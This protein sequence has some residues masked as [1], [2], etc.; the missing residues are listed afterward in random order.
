MPPITL[1][2]LPVL[3]SPEIQ[4]IATDVRAL[5][6]LDLQR[7]VQGERRF[8][9]HDITLEPTPAEPTPAEPTPAEPTPAEL[10]PRQLLTMPIG[11]S[12]EV[13]DTVLFE[14]AANPEKRY[15]L[16]RYELGELDRHELGELEPRVEVKYG[17]DPLGGWT[18]KLRLESRPAPELGDAARDAAPL[19]HTLAVLLRYRLTASDT[20]AEGQTEKVFQEVSFEK[21]GARVA[22]HVQTREERDELYRVLM[23]PNFAATL[24]V[25]RTMRVAFAQS[26]SGATMMHYNIS[27][28]LTGAAPWVIDARNEQDGGAIVFDPVNQILIPQGGARLASVPESSR[29]ATFEQLQSLDYSAEPFQMEFIS[30]ISFPV[31]HFEWHPPDFAVVTRSGLYAQVSVRGDCIL[32]PE[33]NIVR[34]IDGAWLDVVAMKE[35]PPPPPLF[36]EMTITLDH[37]LRKNPFV[38]PQELGYGYVFSD[39]PGTRG[40]E[41]PLTLRQLPWGKDARSYSYYQD[42]VEPHRFYYL[43]DSF[44]LVRQPDS[45]HVPALSVRYA[46]PDG[47]EAGVRATL[48]YAAC[49]YVDA[50]RL[51]AALREL[52]PFVKPPLPPGV[53]GPHLEPLLAEKT[54]LFMRLPRSDGSSVYQELPDAQ[55]DLR[56]GFFDSRTLTQEGF[57]TVFDA[58]FDPFAVLFQG[59]VE[60]VIPRRPAE[61]IPLVAR[62]DDMVGSVL[63]ADVVPSEG[64]TGLQVTLRNAI[65]SPVQL[66]ELSLSLQRG[67]VRTAGHLQAPF[68]ALPV[69]LKPEDALSFTVAPAEPLPGTG[70]WELAID[71]K[72]IKVLPERKELVKT[73]LRAD[74]LAEYKRT[75]DVWTTRDV[76]PSNSR[77]MS[78]EF[79]GGST[80]NF[81]REATGEQHANA[82]VS[83]PIKDLLIKQED[84]GTYEWRVM[85]ISWADAGKTTVHKTPEE[86][87]QWKKSTAKSLFVAT[88]DLPPP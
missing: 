58:L 54:R 41:S 62:L 23:N 65:E 39:L 1:S 67:S 10:K 21:G 68:P 61:R 53:T 70:R 77:F 60:V 33:D 45:P 57:R 37:T 50:A 28:H 8:R 52:A 40:S 76:F 27:V 9:I 44:K 24:V 49:P 25:R 4:M 11:L 36:R 69:T 46:S 29:K 32:S 80:I 73:V 30:R 71:P 59:Y 79:K 26:S 56:T 7:V 5:R 72:G 14:D 47:T 82:E 63:D 87:L 86:K 85:L 20:S 3:A 31:D 81:S 55:V 78:I 66:I 19:E 43:P 6:Q 12:P 75:I 38:F 13:S 83:I 2:V 35:E 18:L 16:P 64:G 34:L 84:P 88:G 51:E 42:P 22:L 48:D 74:T 15:F 17:P